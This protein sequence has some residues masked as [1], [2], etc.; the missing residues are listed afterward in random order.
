MSA[1]AWM[2]GLVLVLAPTVASLKVPYQE[3][4]PS[5]LQV[6]NTIRSH[7]IMGTTI[8]KKF[9]FRGAQGQQWTHLV[10]DVKY[11]TVFR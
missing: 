11:M 2:Q 5:F 4:F 1:H 10:M 6:S 8:D 3:N 9:N 7:D